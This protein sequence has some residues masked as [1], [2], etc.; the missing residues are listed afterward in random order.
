MTLKGT[1]VTVSPPRADQTVQPLASAVLRASASRAVLP[2]PAS[3]PNTSRLPE[4][5]ASARSASTACATSAISVSRSQ[6]KAEAAG[7]GRAC[8]IPLPPQAA[9][10][11]YRHRA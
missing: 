11:T 4:D 5:E 7:P 8:V 9:R 3:P 1:E 10:T 6:R 2:M